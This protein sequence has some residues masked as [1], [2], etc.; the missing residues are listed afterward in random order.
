MLFMLG[1]LSKE[2]HITENKVTIF[3]YDTWH[4]RRQLYYK[5]ILCFMNIFIRP[6]IIFSLQLS[7]II[8]LG[9]YVLDQYKVGHN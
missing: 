7:D 5:H 6:E 3:S 2:P 9:F 4:C 8:L 1:F